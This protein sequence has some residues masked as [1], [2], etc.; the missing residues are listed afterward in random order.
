[1]ITLKRGVPVTLEFTSEDVL[2]G[3]NAPDFETRRD[4]VPGQVARVHLKPEKLGTFTFLCD[5]FCGTGHENM[6]GVI[7]VVE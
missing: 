7:K 4:I 1:V 5:V 3:F 6:N 2:M